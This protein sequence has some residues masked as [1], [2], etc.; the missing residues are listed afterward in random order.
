LKLK[1][2]YTIREAYPRGTDKWNRLVIALPR[3]NN[4]RTFT[5]AVWEVRSPWNNR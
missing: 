5:N 3:V 1:V 4:V 2:L